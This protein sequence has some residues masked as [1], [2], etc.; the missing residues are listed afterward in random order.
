MKTLA[1]INKTIQRPLPFIL[2]TH[3]G[4]TP[5]CERWPRGD[6]PAP[7]STPS[8]LFILHTLQNGSPGLQHTVSLPPCERLSIFIACD[9]PCPHTGNLYSLP[10]MQPPRVRLSILPLGPSAT[11]AH[12]TAWSGRLEGPTGTEAPR[13]QAPENCLLNSKE[14]CGD[15]DPTSLLNSSLKHNLC[16]MVSAFNQQH[17]YLHFRCLYS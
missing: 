8:S 6:A 5:C 13:A 3:L 9:I 10:K 4:V 15:K 14:P 1:T 12:L 16:L 11:S 2:E 17:R 7:A